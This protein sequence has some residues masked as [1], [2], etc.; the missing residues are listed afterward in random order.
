VVRERKL[1]ELISGIILMYV[2]QSWWN[3]NVFFN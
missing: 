2:G 3:D 1:I